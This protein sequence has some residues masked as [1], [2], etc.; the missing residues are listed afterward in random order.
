MNGELV[1][2]MPAK[3]GMFT[4]ASNQDLTELAEEF[5]EMLAR[6]MRHGC[7]EEIHRE[8][9]R[10]IAEWQRL[11][12]EAT[13]AAVRENVFKFLVRAVGVVMAGACWRAAGFSQM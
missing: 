8:V 3:W 9:L 1:I 4:K 7:P 11:G 12:G 13:D 5:L 2:E 10:F 6:H